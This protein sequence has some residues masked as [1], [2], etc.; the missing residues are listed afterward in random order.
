MSELKIVKRD[1]PTWGLPVGDVFVP[2]YLI[3]ELVYQNALSTE[4]GAEPVALPE[5]MRKAMAA[6]DLLIQRTRGS[7]Y[8]NERLKAVWREWTGEDPDDD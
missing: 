1:V 4:F 5:K 7:V 6:E 8:G 3:E 2:T